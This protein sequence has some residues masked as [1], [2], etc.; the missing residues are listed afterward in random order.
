MT[1]HNSSLFIQPTNRQTLQQQPA[2]QKQQQQ[3]YFDSSNIANPVKHVVSLRDYSICIRW[4]YFFTFQHRHSTYH[5]NT[6]SH[7]YPTAFK[8]CAGID[9]TH[10]VQIGRWLGCPC[11]ISETLTCKMLI[12]GRDIGWRRCAMSWCDINVTFDLAIVTL[13]FKFLSSYIPETMKCKK[14]ILD[15]DIS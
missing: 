9:F 2:P 11:C 14:L 13:T 1:S 10:G 5:S 15:R 7:F 6:S 8:D 4:N 12:L 3:S